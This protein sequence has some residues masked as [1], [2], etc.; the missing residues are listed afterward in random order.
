MPLLRGYVRSIPGL[1]EV[2]QRA[3]LHRAGIPAREGAPIYSDNV[4]SFPAQ[5]K[6]LIRSLRPGAGDIV[7]VAML[8]CLAKD[9]NDL[10]AVMQAIADQGATVLE[11]QTGRRSNSPDCTAMTLDAVQYWSGRNRFYTDADEAR[12]A[13]AIGG[14]TTAERVRKSRMPLDM[15]RAIWA[16]KENIHRSNE[17]V[18]HLINKDRRWSVKWSMTTAY[19][20][21]GKREAFP[22]RR[23]KKR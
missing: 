6:A 10:R 2:R 21:L 4:G 7:L 16:G 8:C 19:R 20:L 18:L 1:S 17:D 11:A 13:G 15:A 12:E 5:R 3:A 22:G 9:R 23:S 14:K